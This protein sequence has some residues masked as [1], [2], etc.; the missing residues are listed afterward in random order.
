MDEENNLA[1]HNDSQSEQQQAPEQQQQQQPEPSLLGKGV[2]P[3]NWLPEKFRVTGEDGSFDL[4]ASSKKLAESYK[5][6]EKIKPQNTP[7]S[8]DGYEIKFDESVGLD[9]DTFNQLVSDE[10]AQAF[11]KQAH[12]NGLSN[13]QVNFVVGE[14]LKRMGGMAQAD[15]DFDIEQTKQSL[16][17]LWKTKDEF[18]HNV[19]LA[20]AAFNAFVPVKFQQYEH[21]I[22][23]NPAMMAILAQVGREMQEDSP[24]SQSIN[25]SI[26]GDLET[27]QQSDAYWDKSHPEH[28][29]TSAKVK[30]AYERKYGKELV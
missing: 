7:E 30:R 25:A 11:M 23:Q 29:A 2:E 18:D 13:E 8:A 22:G 4:E 1:Q 16:S 5:N 14:Y 3:D 21:E 27:L 9:E 24:V 19:Q 20:Q 6:I 12:E 26:A 28:A 15:N 17:Q 10:S